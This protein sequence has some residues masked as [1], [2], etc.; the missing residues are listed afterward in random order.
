MPCRDRASHGIGAGRLAVSSVSWASYAGFYHAPL[1]GAQPQKRAILGA[2]SGGFPLPISAL[3]DWLAWRSA[4]VDGARGS[5]PKNPPGACPDGPCTPVHRPR[6]VELWQKLVH[7][8]ASR[9]CEIPN[10]SN[11]CG[12]TNLDLDFWPISKCLWVMAFRGSGRIKISEGKSPG[13]APFGE[14]EHDLEEA[15]EKKGNSAA[16]K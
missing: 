14:R 2:I 9:L 3:L 11:T 7:N 13:S 8:Q 5:P 1:G 12:G 10:K 15:S 4:C 16:G 6:G